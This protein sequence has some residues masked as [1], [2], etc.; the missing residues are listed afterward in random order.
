[1][2]RLTKEIEEE[3]IYCK[4]KVEGDDVTGMAVDEDWRYDASTNTGGR[5]FI[6][7]KSELMAQYGIN[8]GASRL[9]AMG[10]SVKTEKKAASSRENGKK[11]GRPKK[12]NQA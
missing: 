10:G 4:V 8:E 9:G 6:G 7:Y 12:E 5:K 3:G 1:M 11:G 2:S